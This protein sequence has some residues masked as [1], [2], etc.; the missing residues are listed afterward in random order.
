MIKLQ[1][2]ALMDNFIG[3]YNISEIFDSNM[4]PFMELLLFKKNEFIYKE[5]EHVKYL[6][7]IVKGKSK[8]FTTLSN[9]KSLLLCFYDAFKVIG[10]AE[11]VKGQA[12]TSNVQAIEDT[13]C[14]SISSRYFDE[15]L[16]NDIRFL[17]Y[18]CDSLGQKLIRC[19]RNSAI[20]LLYSLENR[21]A[22]YIL[23][24]GEISGKDIRSFVFADNLSEISELLGTSYRHLLRTIYN[25]CR[26]G[27]FQKKNG[28]Y[29]VVN[30][31]ALRELAADLYH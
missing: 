23:A 29:E 11:I 7:F 4:E 15:Y 8:V 16:L 9:G 19:S 30:E 12:A 28:Y 21:L 18:I 2:P 31:T 26:K 20:N 14:V 13:Y 5:G 27:V 6:H 25:L 3:K 22:S 10:D 24:T 1:D 17:R